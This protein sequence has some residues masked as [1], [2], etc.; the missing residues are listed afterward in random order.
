[1][2]NI[3]GY[4][5]Q[6]HHQNNN[7][8]NTNTYSTNTYSTQPPPQSFQASYSSNSHYGSHQPQMLVGLP[9]AGHSK[10]DQFPSLQD[11]YQSDP[12]KMNTFQV[13]G[14]HRL[15]SRSVQIHSWISARAG[16]M[17]RN[18]VLKLVT[19]FDTVLANDKP[20]LIQ[21]PEGDSQ[22]VMYI[23]DEQLT[24]SVTEG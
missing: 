3:N 18:R 10:E 13:M 15:E 24:A 4:S 14:E 9:L 23:N 12:A 2:S 16:N 5:Q 7:S 19:E 11:Y 22:R 17:G 20:R 6:I 8:H 21:I 1:M